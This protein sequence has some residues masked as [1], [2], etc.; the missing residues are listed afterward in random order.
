MLWFYLQTAE[1][2]IPLHSL[3]VFLSSQRVCSSP[4]VAH[5]SHPRLALTAAGAASYKGKPRKQSQRNRYVFKQKPNKCSSKILIL[6]LI[7]IIIYMNKFTH[8]DCMSL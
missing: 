4:A 8:V 2:C 5:V 3:D 6:F 1:T 7:L